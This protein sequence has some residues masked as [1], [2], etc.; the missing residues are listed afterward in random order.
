MENAPIIKIS[1]WRQDEE[2]GFFAGA[3]A[4][5]INCIADLEPGQTA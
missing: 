3:V 2:Q 4:V 1:K 5:G